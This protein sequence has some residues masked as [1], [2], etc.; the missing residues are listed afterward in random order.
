MDK[1]VVEERKEKNSCIQCGKVLKEFKET[2]FG[3]QVFKVCKEECEKLFQAD[4]KEEREINL[5]QKN[6]DIRKLERELI[7]KETQ[8]KTGSLEKNE[9][10]LTNLLSFPKDELKPKFILESEAEVIKVMLGKKRE[11]LKNMEEQ[12][13]KST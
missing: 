3:G 2:K 9:S 13:A 1:G 7:Y 4:M 5:I 12:N 11:E 6:L 10:K 8:I